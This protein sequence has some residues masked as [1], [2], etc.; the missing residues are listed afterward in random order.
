MDCITQDHDLLEDN[1]LCLSTLFPP[2]GQYYAN[3]MPSLWVPLSIK[4]LKIIFSTDIMTNMLI[5]SKSL[6]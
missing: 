1:R 6:L 2:Q 5:T 4:I 3:I